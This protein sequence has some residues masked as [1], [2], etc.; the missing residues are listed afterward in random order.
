MTYYIKTEPDPGEK[1]KPEILIR[2][3]IKTRR[4]DVGLPNEHVSE[5]PPLIDEF[6]L[7]PERLRGDMIGEI[8]TVEED[9]DEWDELNNPTTGEEDVQAADKE[10]FDDDVLPP[11]EELS[12]IHI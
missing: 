1:K 6:L 2:S 12:L 3:L 7:D 8:E 10:R 9:A 5:N 4:K 11:E